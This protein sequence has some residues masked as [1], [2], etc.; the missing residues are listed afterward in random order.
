MQ[1]KDIMVEPIS[2]DKADVTSA[3]YGND[4]PVKCH[5]THIKT[6]HLLFDTYCLDI[7]KVSFYSRF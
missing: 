3:G 2:I 4:L 1:V 7:K 6:V 5:D